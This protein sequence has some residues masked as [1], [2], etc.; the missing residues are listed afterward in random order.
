MD[1][2][3]ALERQGRYRD[4]LDDARHAVDR[5]EAAGQ[6]DGQARA[7]NAVGWYHMLLGDYREAF[8]CGQLALALHSP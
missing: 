5:Y 7:L 8:A 2:A 4:A 1:I 3:C 6:R